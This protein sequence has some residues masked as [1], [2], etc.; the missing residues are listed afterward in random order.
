MKH[1]DKHCHPT[2][3][4]SYLSRPTISSGLFQPRLKEKENIN[5]ICTGIF[6]VIRG[7]SPIENDTSGL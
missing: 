7:N 2:E 3:L 4:K 1:E 6:R 5:P